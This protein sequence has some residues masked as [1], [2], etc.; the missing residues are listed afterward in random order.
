MTITADGL[1]QTIALDG[2]RK[3]RGNLTQARIR[4]MVLAVVL[5]F[6]AGLYHVMRVS[7]FFPAADTT[8]GPPGS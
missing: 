4:W 3:A 8:Q 1:P 5:G 2:V 6:A 7:G